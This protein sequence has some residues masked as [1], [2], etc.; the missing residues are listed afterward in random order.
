LTIRLTR[1]LAPRSIELGFDAESRTVDRRTT[2][3]D[4]ILDLSLGPSLAGLI[5]GSGNCSGAES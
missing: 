4:A 5:T 1:Y 2:I 3:A